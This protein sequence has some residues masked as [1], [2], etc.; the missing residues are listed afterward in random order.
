MKYRT[1]GPL[2]GKRVGITGT[3][4]FAGKLAAALSEQGAQVSWLIN[5]K[6]EDHIDEAPMQTA[7]RNLSDY[8]WLMF[9]SANGVRL[10]FQGL[11]KDGRDYRCL[12]HVKFA[13]IRDGKWAGTVRVWI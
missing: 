10:F 4:Q 9:T 12:G 7:Y 11:F 1:E 5:M 13:V 6:V 3:E 2:A 8:T